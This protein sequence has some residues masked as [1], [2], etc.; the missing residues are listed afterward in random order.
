MSASHSLMD[1]HSRTYTILL[2]VLAFFCV[3]SVITMLSFSQS[4]TM[5][6]ES[7]WVFVMTAAIEA[8]FVVA[9][10]VT[11]ILRGT[12]PAAGRIATK[13]LNIVL[14]VLFPFG[15]ALGIY[16]LMKV[17]RDGQRADA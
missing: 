1:N 3:I 12:A 13:A 8:L 9:I 11:L 10:I 4:P 14:L 16:G 2:I 5:E 6:P 7:R 15:T 17:D